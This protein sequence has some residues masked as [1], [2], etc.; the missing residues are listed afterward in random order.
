M[1]WIRTVVVSAALLG[2]AGCAPYSQAELGLIAQARRGVKLVGD[3]ESARRAE[4]AELAGQRRARVDDAFDADVRGRASIDAEWVI[5]HRRAYAAALDAMAKQDA[6]AAA[7]DEA[8]A[9]NLAA[10][11]QVLAQLESMV[12]VEA[13]LVD[14]TEVKQ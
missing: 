10:I 2:A 5:V 4:R 6:A 9:R 8:T 12:G 7:A 11:D 3:A 1:R 13:K 14:L